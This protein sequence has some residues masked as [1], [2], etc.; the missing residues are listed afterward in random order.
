M[1]MAVGAWTLCAKRWARSVAKTRL[2]ICEDALR[3]LRVLA[4]GENMA[5]DDYAVAKAAL[6]AEFDL[7]KSVQGFTWTFDLDTVPNQYARPM[8]EALA[9]LIAAEFPLPGQTVPN[10]SRAVGRMRAIA[11]PDDRADSRDLDG[12]GTVSTAEAN[13]AKRAAYY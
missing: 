9:A 1:L 13:V 2:D 5:A 4:V 11:F 8:A 10:Y 6:E 12:D 7:W 3:M